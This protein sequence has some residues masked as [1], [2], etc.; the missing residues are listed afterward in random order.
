MLETICGI[1]KIRTQKSVLD[2]QKERRN[3]MKFQLLPNKIYNSS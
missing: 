1:E 2:C 3:Y